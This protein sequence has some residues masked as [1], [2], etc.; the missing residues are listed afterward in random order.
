MFLFFFCFFFSGFRLLKKKKINK[1]IKK[2]NKRTND[3]GMNENEVAENLQIK[4]KNKKI[5]STEIKHPC[6][7]CN[8]ENSRIHPGYNIRL[9]DDCRVSNKYKLLTKTH[10]K[11]MYHLNETD[12][13]SI[14]QQMAKNPIF[15]SA[16]MMVLIK[17]HDLIKCFCS[18]YKIADVDNDNAITNKILELD[19]KSTKRK[20]KRAVTILK[21]KEK[22]RNELVAVFVKYEIKI[23]NDSKLCVGFIDNTLKNW[24]AE[25]VAKRMCQ[26]KYLHDY[27]DFSKFHEKAYQN[28]REE[29]QAGY[30]ND[31]TVSEDAEKM[32]IKSIGGK[33]PTVWPWLHIS[34]MQKENIIIY[35]CLAKS[36]VFVPNHI[37][38]NLKTFLKNKVEKEKKKQIED[39]R[40]IQ[41]AKY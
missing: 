22:R 17:Q 36:I 18:K 24:S 16:S 7:E 2:M 15:S 21:N 14:P 19:E 33:Y 31:T 8:A 20:E 4:S 12:L 29:R 11:Q 27:C 38:I 35:L 10:A 1:Q 41:I 32:A 6:L 3:D 34:Q 30:H 5:K 37:M 26:M 9:C 28:Q 13:E 25:E 40:K 39:V 23:R